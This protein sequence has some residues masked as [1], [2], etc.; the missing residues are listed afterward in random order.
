MLAV[1]PA[2]EQALENFTEPE[3]ADANAGMEEGMIVVVD[4]SARSTRVTDVVVVVDVELV[5]VIVIW[6]SVVLVTLQKKG[7]RNIM[8]R[9]Y[10]EWPVLYVLV[11]RRSNCIYCGRNGNV[12]NFRRS[13]S[14]NTCRCFFESGSGCCK[15]CRCSYNRAES[16][17]VSLRGILSR[18]EGLRC[19]RDECGQEIRRTSSGA[20][21]AWGNRASNS[22]FLLVL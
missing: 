20:R 22:C 2:Q 13:C 17:R 1:T 18:E 21:F 5:D 6:R 4:P 3:H 10:A 7:V 19:G 12:D 11:S 14:D 15:N 16:F 9:K 8:S